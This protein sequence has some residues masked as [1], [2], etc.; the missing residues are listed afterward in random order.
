MFQVD[1]RFSLFAFRFSLFAFRFSLVAFRLS[2]VAVRLSFVA[3]F[4][5]LGHRLPLIDH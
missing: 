4:W 3:G 5:S 1:G 2:L